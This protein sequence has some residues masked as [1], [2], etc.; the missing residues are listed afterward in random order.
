VQVPTVRGTAVLYED[1][2]PDFSTV[3]VKRA[4]GGEEKVVCKKLIVCTG[5]SPMRPDSFPY[6]DIRV[7]DSGLMRLPL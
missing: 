1:D 4:D 6:D 2:D 5:S 3:L 7:F